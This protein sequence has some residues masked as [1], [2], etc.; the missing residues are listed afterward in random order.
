M[1]EKKKQLAKELE[2][3][4]EKLQIDKINYKCNKK[5]NDFLKMFSM[6]VAEVTPILMRVKQ[7]ELQML[8]FSGFVRFLIYF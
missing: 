4:I 7:R 6:V 3:R 8:L 5:S 2:T 1:K